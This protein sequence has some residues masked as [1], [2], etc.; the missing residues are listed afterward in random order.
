MTITK[1][2]VAEREI[3]AAVQLLFDGGDAIPIYVLA[4][5]AREITTTLCEKRGL[6]SMVDW[7]QVDHPH[8][9]RK[10]I[11]RE[12]SKPAAFF[13]HANKD[14]DAVLEDFDPTEA[15]TV[16]YMACADLRNLGRRLPVEGD[17]FDLWFMAVRGLLDQL[18][19]PHLEGLGGIDM[20]PR[21]EQIVMG[22]RFLDAARAP[23]G[24]TCVGAGSYK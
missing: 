2:D 9:S 23:V 21:A 20:V 11:H 15:D 14:P 10:D 8:M 12:A 5:S 13:K 1:L 7:I 22:K 3:V 24:H 4:N 6:H 19:L 16:L 18:D 17:A